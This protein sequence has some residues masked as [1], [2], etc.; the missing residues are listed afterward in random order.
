M[1]RKYLVLSLL[2]IAFMGFW[3]IG[4]SFMNSGINP[5]GLIGIPLFITQ[6]FQDQEVHD[7]T[8]QVIVLGHEDQLS[9]TEV[10]Q[11]INSPVYS[12]FANGV[13]ERINPDHE[14]LKYKVTIPTIDDTYLSKNVEHWNNAWRNELDIQ[15]GIYGDEFY[16]ELGR[17]LIKNEMQ[18][19]MNNL[20]IIN[21]EDDFEVY[22]G[23]ALQS[24]P[25]HIGYSAV[26]HATD[27]NY[28]RLEGG[29]NA[30]KV[31]F[32]RTSQL[33]FP[34]TTEKL[35]I[36]S[37]LSNP[38]LITIIP[39]NG[40]KA[41]QE[42][43]TLVVQIDN[44]LVEFFNNTPETIRIQDNGSGMVGEE[45]TLDW[46][47]PIILPY[48]KATMT[49]DKPGLYEWDARNAPN[50]DRPLWWESHANGYV[51][52][53]SD[54]MNDFSKDDKARIAQKMLHNSNI[55]LVSSGAGN[56]EKVLKL[57][58]DPAV[59]NTVPDVEEYYL[60]RSHQLIPF[61][62]EIVMYE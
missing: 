32:Y 46:M 58:L 45:N 29:T 59:I 23:M 44:N 33:Q 14:P 25:P 4:G 18:Y 42:P 5:I 10:P 36:E 8:S 57:G 24:L 55:P 1:K 6:S 56:V 16:T 3:M 60:Q 30:N 19:Q 37:L 21:T 35:S 9:D 20:G 54:D 62:V 28:Y 12:R 11:E 40:N 22:S 15:Y 13:T 50:L 53:L 61:D 47:G 7:N 52:V 39:E 49:F 41:R 43:S 51:V 2:G 38:Q 34:D 17:L 31:S 26:V 48:Q 27:G